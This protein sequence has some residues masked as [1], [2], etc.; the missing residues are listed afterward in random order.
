MKSSGTIAPD[1]AVAPELPSPVLPKL[2]HFLPPS[3]TLFLISLFDLPSLWHYPLP[4]L[5]F[6]SAA[7]CFGILWGNVLL[8]KCKHCPCVVPPVVPASLLLID[9]FLS[10]LELITRSTKGSASF[11]SWLS[12]SVLRVLGL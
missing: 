2:L 7:P 10:R 9:L 4:S 12:Q 11:I 1:L 3:R 5:V 6:G 8:C